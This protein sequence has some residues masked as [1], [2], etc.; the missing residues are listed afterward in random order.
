M[1][2]VALASA[3]FTASLFGGA[4]AKQI[5]FLPSD[6]LQN[7]LLEPSPA[8]SSILRLLVLEEISPLLCN[9]LEISSRLFISFSD[10]MH[11]MYPLDG[12]KC[13]IYITC[14]Q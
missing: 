13:K 14:E 12:M 9:K 10:F 8:N 7:F 2:L 4:T 5:L 3:I 1:A 6:I 11:T